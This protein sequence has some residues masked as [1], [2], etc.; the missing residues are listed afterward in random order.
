M[1]M[2]GTGFEEVAAGNGLDI[3]LTKPFF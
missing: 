2:S 1:A 3:L